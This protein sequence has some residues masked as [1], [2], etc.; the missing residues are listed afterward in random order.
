MKNLKLLSFIAVFSVVMLYPTK[1]DA[2][3]HSGNYIDSN[4]CLVVWSYDTA[5]FGLIKYNQSEDVFCNSDGSPMDFDL[6]SFPC[7]S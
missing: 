3:H 5:F 2:R 4:G 7:C 1:A 6:N